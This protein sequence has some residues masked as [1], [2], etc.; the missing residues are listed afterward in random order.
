MDSVF[1]YEPKLGRKDWIKEVILKESWIVEMS[2]GHE[3]AALWS[4]EAAILIGSY[5]MAEKDVMG[6]FGVFNKAFYGERIN[7]WRKTTQSVRLSGY[8]LTIL[9]M[10][11]PG[12]MTDLFRKG[13]SN[14]TGFAKE[15]GFLRDFLCVLHQVLL[16]IGP[17]YPERNLLPNLI[18]L[19]KELRNSSIKKSLMIGIKSRSYR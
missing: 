2:Q 4:D 16:A 11:Q 17:M 8:R 15:T 14:E 13:S 9:L 6:F 5:G 10:M 19:K 1:E 3:S 7:S 12:V 18:D